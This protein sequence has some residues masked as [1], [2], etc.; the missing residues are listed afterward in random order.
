MKQF[1]RVVLSMMALAVALGALAGVATAKPAG[2]PPRSKGP[3]KAK[4]APAGELDTSFGLGGKVVVAF[5]AENAGTAGPKYTLPFEFTPGHLEM[6]GAPGGKVVIAG[7]RKIVR[8][9]ANGKPD[10]SFGT[11]GTV[12]VP[13]PPGALFVLAGV[14][15]DS[16]GR[17]VLA[18][19]SRPIPSESTPDPVLSKATVMRFNADGTLD[20]SFGSGGM[21]VTDFGFKAPSAPGGPYIGASVGLRDVTIDAANRPVL[22]GGYVTELEKYGLK[23]EGF[24]ARLTESGALDPSFGSGGIRTIGSFDGFSQ[25]LAR[26]TG[27]LALG[28]PS[29][30]P[31]NV[32][33]GLDENGNLDPSFGAFG[34]RTL[35]ASGEPAVAIAPSGKIL[36]LSR[37]E[38]SHYFKTETRRNKKTGKKERVKVRIN[39]KIQNVRRL[40]PSGASDPSFGRTGSVNYIDPSV[41]SFAALT[42]DN[43]ERIYLAGR[44]GRRVAK[45]ANNPLHRTQFLLQRTQADGR[46]D[47]SFGKEGAVTTGFGGPSDAFATQVELVAKGKILVGGGITSP[48][49]ETGGGFALARYLPGK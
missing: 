6:A 20:Q 30:G 9:L 15:V 13:S 2:K 41:G 37:P 42:V 33:T 3:S 26:S 7:A 29:E 16:D 17:V 39:V 24:V 36:L 28:Q 11:G 4:T 44:V 22:T 27:W 45:N 46:F 10:P 12:S 5:P 25:L 38:N 43:Q 18:G 19:L 31:R 35:K 14:A 32:L 40:L 48:E 1:R 49:L 8:Y 47:N 21:V 34:F 23:S